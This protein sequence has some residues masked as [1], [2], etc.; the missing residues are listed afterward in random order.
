MHWYVVHISFLD[1]FISI[2]PLASYFGKIV[3]GPTTFDDESNAIFDTE[4][5][6]LIKTNALYQLVSSLKLG[7]FYYQNNPESEFEYDILANSKRQ[8]V[9]KLT[10]SFSHWDGN[11]QGVLQL[12][13][14]W[15]FR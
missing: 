10:A 6:I 3:M 12:R 14:K 5:S 7:Q 8:P 15:N 13:T 4:K 1:H 2:Q 11:E 9:F